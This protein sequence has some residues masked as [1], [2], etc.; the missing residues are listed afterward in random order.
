MKSSK[1][2]FISA[3]TRSRCPVCNGAKKLMVTDEKKTDLSYT[4]F[5]LI[6]CSWCSGKKEKKK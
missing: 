5:K 1:D 3:R 4:K 2:Y 6:D